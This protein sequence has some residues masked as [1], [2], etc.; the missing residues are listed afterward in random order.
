VAADDRACPICNDQLHLVQLGAESAD[1]WQ[2]I[3][4]SNRTCV[5][6]TTIALTD[7]TST[8][9][10]LTTARNSGHSKQR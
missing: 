5:W 3:R 10:P 7:S 2:L 8:G 9:V 4:R 1:R 6:L